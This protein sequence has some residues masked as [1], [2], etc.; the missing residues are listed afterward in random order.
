[1]PVL[2]HA[3]MAWVLKGDQG[4]SA[5]P[6][7]KATSEN[8]TNGFETQPHEPI[9]SS[10]LAAGTHQMAESRESYSC[11]VCKNS[12][13]HLCVLEWHSRHNEHLT[14]E[15]SV[16]GCDILFSDS[17]E[18]NAH[19]RRPHLLGHG[20]SVTD[21]QFRCIECNTLCSS[22]AGLLRHGKQAQHR[23]YGCDCGMLFSRL[24]VLHRHL[25]SLALEEPQ[26]PC[27]YQNCKRHR[28]ANGFHR[29]DHLTQH[30]RN[31]HHVGTVQGPANTV[32]GIQRRQ[33]VFPVCAFS[34]C[35]QYRDPSFNSLPWSQKEQNK[36]FTSQSA[37]TKHMRYEHNYCSFPCIVEGCDRT[38]R[39]GYF[40]EKDL[41]KHRQTDHPDAPTYSPTI[42]DMKYTCTEPGCGKV[43]D[44]SSLNG[45]MWLHEIRSLNFAKTIFT[46]STFDEWIGIS[47]ICV[48]AL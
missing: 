12:Y 18:R 45:H 21:N 46:P 14:L 20:R 37:Y 42:R 25:E 29:K 11:R 43:I 1:M 2:I 24:D 13:K 39:R 44:P 19:Q 10:D 33:F 8:L 16:H 48:S 41:I 23:P 9:S 40:R 26:F 31:Y 3:M 28:G 27:E 17:L 15:C 30:L 47:D 35:P 32:I 22:K 7:H 34:S 36:P 38:G 6:F 4:R 5:G